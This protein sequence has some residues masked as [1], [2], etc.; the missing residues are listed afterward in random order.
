[1]IRNVSKLPIYTDIETLDT[2]CE[3]VLNDGNKQINFANLINLQEYVGYMDPKTFSA[4][5]AKMARHEFL[6]LY[7]EAKMLKGLTSRKLAIKYV[8]SNCEP[9]LKK[10]IQR[11]IL[12]SIEPGNL[13]SQDIQFINNMVYVKL[14]MVFLQRYKLGLGKI[15]E[16]LDSDS[17]VDDQDMDY[18][19]EYI[20]A[21]LS[22]LNK[23]KR[24]SRKENRFNLTDPVLF[25]SVM[26]EACDRL[27]SESNHLST[28]FK[29]L[30]KL[31]N[32][33]LENARIY[34]FIGAT[35]GFKSGLLLNLMKTV[36][37]NNVGRAHK[38]MNKRPT[39]LFISQ[40]NNL[41]ETINRIFSIFGK[42]PDNI[43]NYTAEEIMKILR[44]GGFCL[45][46]NEEDIDIEFRYYGNADVS[47]PDLKGM[48]EELEN[49]GR[50]VILI[51]QDYIERFRPPNP[52]A[53][54]R[55]QL[56]DIANLM[57]DT[58]QE[59][60]IPIVTGSQFNKQGV[61]TI[62]TMQQ[63]GKYDIGRHVG[64]GDI[65]ESFGMLKNFDVNIGI[66]IEY[67]SKEERYYLSFR[68]L[69]LR[70]EDGEIDYFLQPFV[71][72]RSK[73]QLMEDGGL[74]DGVYRLSLADEDY[75]NIKES[76]EKL[77][78]SVRKSR[79]LSKPKDIEL[80]DSDEPLFLENRIEAYSNYENIYSET[81]IDEVYDELGKVCGDQYNA[82]KNEYSIYSYDE[83]GQPRDKDGFIVLI[84]KI[85]F[86]F[87][88]PIIR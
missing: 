68:R 22:E 39:I 6:R 16:D 5:D 9:R 60:D 24:R 61:T 7:L 12:D 31:L 65:S 58:A 78:R 75:A 57:H 77:D 51:I 4:N 74:E 3:Y 13:K 14:N 36:K 43:R 37:K 18:C 71:G 35:G 29:G 80:T 73:I 50:E 82:D 76:S 28:G 15:I 1:M 84:P 62:E 2:Y 41:W 25:K 49:Q 10:I 42:T 48:V 8:M 67:D 86:S 53:E 85:D 17:F 54:R 26:S 66:V 33:G 72:K 45:V 70:G 38:D 27:L 69:K 20:Q 87:S 30:D 56:F 64:T 40:E 79:K 44:D 34:N 47:V 23:A 52:S 21:L 81:E 55:V 59:L 19:L 32:G 11:E 88:L 63:Q 83:N 46:D